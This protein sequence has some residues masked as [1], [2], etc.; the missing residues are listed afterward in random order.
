MSVFLKWASTMPLRYEMVKL[1]FLQSLEKAWGWSLKLG[2][3]WM[4]NVCSL[5][6]SVL[7]KGLGSQTFEQELSP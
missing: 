3:N 5:V 2:C 4:R 1:T 6:V 7:L